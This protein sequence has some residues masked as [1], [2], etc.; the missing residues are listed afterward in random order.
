[1]RPISICREAV[2]LLVAATV[3]VLLFVPTGRAAASCADLLFRDAFETGDT[4]R[5]ANSPD[6][7]RA[8][9]TWTFNLDFTGTTRAFAVELME[10]SG[11]SVTG[12]LLG[13][14][15]ERVLVAGSVSGSTLTLVLELAHPTA[16]R[17]ITIT[18]ALGRD[19]IV[20]AAS[21]DLTPQPV[22]LERTDCELFEQHLAAAVDTGGGTPEHLRYPGGRARRRR[23]LRRRRF[24]G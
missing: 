24:V 6:P 15:R 17:T 13:G 22:T 5:W 23:R 12:Y 20:G 16:T 14:T 4:S 11:G 19:T 10:R 2:P 1:M 3:V 7:A 21:G 18:G 9:G 8:T